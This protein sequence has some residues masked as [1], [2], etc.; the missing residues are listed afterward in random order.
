MMAS[1][2]KAAKDKK[3]NVS[4]VT[5]FSTDKCEIEV[6]LSRGTY[7]QDVVDALY[8][9]TECEKTIAVNLL[10]IQDDTPTVTTV[11]SVIKRCV[12]NLVSILEKE[13]DLKAAD[14]KAK[15]EWKSLED[16]FITSGAYKV[17]EG[18]KTPEDVTKA[19]IAEM[20]KF[21]KTVDSVTVDKL[22]AIP[23]RRT[24][25]YD[26]KKTADEIAKL[27]AELKEV[28]TNRSDVKKYAADW[29]DETIALIKKNEYDGHR[30]TEIAKFTSVDL[31]Q[32][33]VKSYDVKYDEEKG[34]AGTACGGNKVLS[35]TK[36]D[37]V[38]VMRSDASWS[39]VPVTEFDRVFVGKGARILQATKEDLSKFTFVAVSKKDGK[40]FVQH[41]KVLGWTMRKEYR[42]VEGEC[43]V[44]KDADFVC[45]I[46][47]ESRGKTVTEKFD[48]SKLNKGRLSNKAVVR[49]T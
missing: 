14:L 39:V 46:E 7:T 2:E 43:L 31:R 48:T 41:F 5:D 15:V 10:V 28:E 4:S 33:A 23:I 42:P 44:V 21:K 17:V 13:L 3:L 38:F 27:K 29:I 12:K 20:K 18:K 24:S 36:F 26:S 47:L 32:V 37:K 16:V 8:A 22:V 35:L 19:V 11:T 30:R 45:E 9:Y 1:I 49:L 25:N 40:P 34:Y 6:K